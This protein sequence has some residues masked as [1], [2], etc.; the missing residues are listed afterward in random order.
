MTTTPDFFKR[1]TGLRFCRPANPLSVDGEEMTGTILSEPFDNNERLGA[2]AWFVWVLTDDGETRTV[3]VNGLVFSAD[4]CDVL[5]GAVDGDGS[6]D[7]GDGDGNG[8]DHVTVSRAYL[9]GL[10]GY[11]RWAHGADVDVRTV[12]GVAPDISL[13]HARARFPERHGADFDGSMNPASFYTHELKGACREM[14][15]TASGLTNNHK[16]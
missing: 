16:Q 1:L 2:P 7:D 10:V 3:A 13:C 14:P 5:V 11:M 6:G 4:A 12:L 9:N 15:W 8:D